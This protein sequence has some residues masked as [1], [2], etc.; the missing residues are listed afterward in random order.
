MF[1][2]IPVI[3][4]YLARYRLDFILRANNSSRSL[5]RFLLM[6]DMNE[7]FIPG[8]MKRH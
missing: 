4:R 3:M 8:Q 2:I 5:D 7:V 6:V 1:I